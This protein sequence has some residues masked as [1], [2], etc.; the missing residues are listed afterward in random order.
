MNDSTLRLKKLAEAATPG[1]WE[2]SGTGQQVL[3]EA[4]VPYGNQRIC[5]TNSMASHYPG[6]NLCWANVA[7]IAAANP[8]VVLGLIARIEELE[9]QQADKAIDTLLNAPKYLIQD[10]WY[11]QP[12]LMQKLLS[13][14]DSEIKRREDDDSDA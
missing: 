13:M 7:F 2:V 14:I 1:P 10:L 3:K 5:E 11:E 8:E 6:K 4:D 12:A 9:K